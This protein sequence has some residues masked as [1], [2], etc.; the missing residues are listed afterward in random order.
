MDRTTTKRKR[1]RALFLFNG[2]HD[3]DWRI[4][5]GRRLIVLQGPN[6]VDTV[7]QSSSDQESPVSDRTNPLEEI[8]GIK[9]ANIFNFWL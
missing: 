3:L 5:D 1:T 2:N 9:P 7:W 6:I 8:N 4:T